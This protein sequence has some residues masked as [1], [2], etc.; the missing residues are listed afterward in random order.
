MHEIAEQAA[1]II[2]PHMGKIAAITV[3]VTSGRTNLADSAQLGTDCENGRFVTLIAAADLY[4][5]FSSSDAGTVDETAVTGDNRAF[6]LPA[7]QRQDFILRNGYTWIVHKAPVATVLRAYVSSA[8][9][10]ES[11]RV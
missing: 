9:T 4:F 1:H 8:N 10:Y 7:G 3:A 6:Y 2:S 5:F 11:H